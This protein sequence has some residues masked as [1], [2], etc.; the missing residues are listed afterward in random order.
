R[1]RQQNP[2]LFAKI[3]SS[4]RFGPENPDGAGQRPGRRGGGA[5]DPDRLRSRT[6]GAGRKD[7]RT[8][9]TDTLTELYLWLHLGRAHQ[10][11]PTPPPSP[12]TDYES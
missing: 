10:L 1:L 12:L 9:Q 3:R 11:T 7:R 6:P 5:A 8:R 2:G 4:P